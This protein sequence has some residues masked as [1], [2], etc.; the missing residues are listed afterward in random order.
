MKKFSPEWSRTI[1]TAMKRLHP[2]PIDD[3]A[4]LNQ[5]DSFDSNL[6]RT[7]SRLLSGLFA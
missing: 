2:K 7:Y 6:S 5:I 3:R 1:L 4:V